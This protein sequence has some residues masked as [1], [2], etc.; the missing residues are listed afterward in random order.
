M[1]ENRDELLTVGEIAEILGVNKN[2]ILHYDR[3]R[4]YQFNKK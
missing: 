3:K 1:K 4:A 2:T